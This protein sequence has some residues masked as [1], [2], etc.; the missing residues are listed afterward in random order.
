M[1]EDMNN[2]E[3]KKNEYSD[4]MPKEGQH[5]SNEVPS[6]EPLEETVKSNSGYEFERENSEIVWVSQKV[7]ELRQEFSK[8]IIGQHEMVELLLTGIFSNGHLLL[9]GVPGIAKTLSAKVIAKALA[10]DF[11]RIQFTPDMMPSDVIGTSIYNMKDSAFIFNKGPVFANIV[12]IDEINE[13]LQKRNLHC[14]R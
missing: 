9:E 5:S 12:L 14:L 2:N 7:N 13:L 6:N 8:Y 3:E 4:F 11:S 10:I 1:S